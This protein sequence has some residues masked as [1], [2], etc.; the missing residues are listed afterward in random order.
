MDYASDKS[1]EIQALKIR[2][3]PDIGQRKQYPQGR[4]RVSVPVEGTA[5]SR[6]EF[7]ITFEPPA[8]TESSRLARTPRSNS[9]RLPS[10]RAFKAGHDSSP[11][12]SKQEVTAPFHREDHGHFRLCQRLCQPLP[13]LIN[14]GDPR[15]GLKKDPRAPH[16]QVQRDLHL[17]S[18]DT[19][20]APARYCWEDTFA[21]VT[22][23]PSFGV[24]RRDSH[25]N[26]AR[27][28]G[29]AH[30][31]T[32]QQHFTKK[33]SIST[34][35]QGEGGGTEKGGPSILALDSITTSQ[36]L[37][38]LT[39]S[40]A[41][42]VL[43]YCK[44]SQHE[45]RINP[46]IQCSPKNPSS[47]RV[48]SSA[49]TRWCRFVD[50]FSSL[51]AKAARLTCDASI[52]QRPSSSHHPMIMYCVI[53][54]HWDLWLTRGDDCVVDDAWFSRN[55]NADRVKFVFSSERNRLMCVHFSCGL[56]A[57]LSGYL[58]FSIDRQSHQAGHACGVRAAGMTAQ[59]NPSTER[60]HVPR[61]PATP[62]QRAPGSQFS[63]SSP[64]QLPTFLSLA[65]PASQPASFPSNL[66]SRFPPTHARGARMQPTTREMQAMAAAGQIS[67]D[68]LRAAI[69]SGAGAGVHDDF[70]GQMLAW[71]EL[72]SAAGAKAPEVE[73]MQQ[74]HHHQQQ[75]GGG[76]LYEDD[77]PALL[78][79]RLRQHQISGGGGAESTAAKQMV[80]QQQMADVRNGHHHMLL[81]GMGRSTGD[82]GSLLL[83]L[84]LGSGGSGAGGDVQALLKAA[85][86]N[87]AG[88]GGEAAGVFGGAFAGSLQQ[89]QHFQPHPQQ[90][91]QM[92][93]Q[94][95]GGGGGAGAGA[96]QPQ[97]GASGGGAAAPPRQRVRARRGQATDPHS[98]A[99][100]VSYATTLLLPLPARSLIAQLLPPLGLRRE[101]IAERMKALQELVPN[102]NKGFGCWEMMLAIK[103]RFPQ[104]LVANGCRK[105]RQSS[106]R[107]VELAEVCVA[108][109][110]VDARAGHIYPHVGLLDRHRAPSATARPG[111]K[112]EEGHGMAWP[113]LRLEFLPM[114]RAG[115]AS[116]E[117]E[118]D[119][120]EALALL[121]GRPLFVLCAWLT[122]ACFLNECRVYVQTDK[123]T[124]LDE[125]IDYVKFLQLQVLSMSRLGGAGAVAPLV[126]DMSSECHGMQLLSLAFSC[127]LVEL[128]LSPPSTFSPRRKNQRDV[129]KLFSAMA[130]GYCHCHS[131]S[132]AFARNDAPAPRE[133]HAHHRVPESL[134]HVFS[135]QGRGGGAPATAGSDGLAVTE[136]QVAKLM[137]DDMGTAMQY[138]QG[139]GLC[140]M[141]VSLASAISSATCHM[142]PPMAGPA[143]LAGVAHHMVAMRLPHGINGRGADAAAAAVPALPSMSVLTAQS[144]MA[145]GGA[146]GGADGEGSHSQQQQ[147]HPKDAASVSKP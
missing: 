143:G 115:A 25:P 118:T 82:G 78:A 70:L 38:S 145:N 122:A 109:G 67:L 85:A 51:Q 87:S 131:A 125:I 43:P 62:T 33:T 79:S 111:T 45:T 127:C 56:L 15:H 12:W 39:P 71:V 105:S 75:F 146:G 49:I 134:G 93:G 124:M 104:S 50:T 24:G 142:R 97:A 52:H 119:G 113:F 31:A 110:M 74:H 60:R 135:L 57:T 121:S 89:Q 132:R 32:S 120:R 2:R 137:E 69:S 11:L 58:R 83:P 1:S 116:E 13:A 98:I 139:K 46:C 91:A 77:E 35:T 22:L 136:Q 18:I 59:S 65:T 140:L 36:G 101:R 100:R 73:G 141:P 90:T 53:Q 133:H 129:N 63:L 3:R 9:G 94:G 112:I 34:S 103:V 55:L 7:S 76:G 117:W 23:T 14:L 128:R 41:Q 5:R 8:S 114:S 107:C 102:A 28:G 19:P 147:Q 99:E 42:L 16:R 37:E 29:R 123:A 96:P 54:M 17:R 108:G 84:S 6:K 72:A 92:P 20:R 106:I 30:V 88:G 138:L 10:D 44:L 81:Q 64:S 68:D 47:E 48:V 80:L 4:G 86:A 130:D 126:A 144:A 66:A 21:T 40:P 61:P 95:F 26:S 27:Y